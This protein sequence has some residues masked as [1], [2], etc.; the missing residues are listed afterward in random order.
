MPNSI[1]NFLAQS[2]RANWKL[3]LFSLL[4]ILIAGVVSV[5]TGVIP[6]DMRVGIVFNIFPKITIVAAPF[7]LM[8]RTKSHA[9]WQES[10]PDTPIT[11]KDFTTGIYLDVF[12]STFIGVPALA[13][14]WVV[15]SL[16]DPYII[17]FNEGFLVAGGVFCWIW[18]M[19]SLLY[20][21]QFTKFGKHNGG[22]TLMLVCIFV[23]LGFA[24]A[25][26]RIGHAIGLPAILIVTLLMLVGLLM[27]LIG[28]A[29]T[30]R[31]YEKIDL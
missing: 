14:I 20:T 13:L 27:F 29:I 26:T 9:E 11:K 25:L 2:V 21:F 31:L 10:Q 17:D 24:V 12:L 8:M 18:T 6:E 23:S 15:A 19:T 3:V 1:K 28:W 22:Q 16:V 5:I 30:K 7:I 4:L